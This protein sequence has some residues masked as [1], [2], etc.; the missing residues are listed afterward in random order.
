[1]RG[2][3]ICAKFVR[4]SAKFWS[5][6][7]KI[8]NYIEN[9]I[10]IPF[11][12]RNHVNN[13]SGPCL[14]HVTHLKRKNR[15]QLCKNLCFMHFCYDFK[16]FEFTR[17]FPPLDLNK[18]YPSLPFPPFETYFNPLSSTD[19]LHKSCWWELYPNFQHSV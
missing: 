11:K 6:N 4:F 8:R 14:Y 7:V 17:F 1:M 3:T 9:I 19:S 5:I 15:K 13:K 10:C 16:L 12:W 18:F 2:P